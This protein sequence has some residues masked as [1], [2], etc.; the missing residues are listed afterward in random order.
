MAETNHTADNLP[1]Y[2]M[3]NSIAEFFASNTRTTRQK[4]D[5]LAST[6][7]KAPIFPVP[8]QGQF[9]Y[10]IVVGEPATIV[11]SRLPKSDFDPEFLRLARSIHADVVASITSHES[12]GDSPPLSVYVTQTLPG[13]TYMEA[14]L[15]NSAH[16]V[17]SSEQHQR[18][19]NTVIDFAKYD[20][21]CITLSMESFSNCNLDSSLPPGRLRS[22]STQNL[23]KADKL[24]AL[25]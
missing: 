10:T 20:R 7:L 6:L 25:A 8:I 3:D 1:I 21:S 19:R 22:R 2:S 24:T 13:V 4:C 23:S 9:S 16:T 11:Q 17:F 5:E 18:Q 14:C 15:V 12:V